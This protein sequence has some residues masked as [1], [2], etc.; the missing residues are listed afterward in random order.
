MYVAEIDSGLAQREGRSL[1][2]GGRSRSIRE[3]LN[4]RR[5]L[6]QSRRDGLL[7][8][9]RSLRGRWSLL[10]AATA[11]AVLLLRQWQYS[12]RRL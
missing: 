10:S 11:A 8:L 4:A 2:S 1:N 3:E 12:V 6:A 7:Q 5:P 9:H